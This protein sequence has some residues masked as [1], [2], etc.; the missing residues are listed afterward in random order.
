MPLQ[1]L[2]KPRKSLYKSQWWH[3][4]QAQFW[5]MQPAT[6]LSAARHACD[7]LQPVL[8]MLMIAIVIRQLHLSL[9]DVL[10]LVDAQA[11]K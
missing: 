9:I 8:A 6:Y 4:L 1:R 5:L 2:I 7:R 11:L 10:V 3:R